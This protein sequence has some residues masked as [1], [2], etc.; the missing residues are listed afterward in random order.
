M[1]RRLLL[2]CY[3]PHNS[4][5]DSAGFPDLVAAGQGGVIFRELKSAGGDTT[6][7]QDLWGWTLTRAGA[8]WGIWR[9][10]DLASGRIERE[11]SAIR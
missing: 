4:R 7:E 6:A 11:L 10:A 3:H 8:D 5:R 2:C 9:P 1:C